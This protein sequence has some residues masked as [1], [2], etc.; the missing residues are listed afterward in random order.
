M[1]DQ[2]SPGLEAFAFLG[3]L[4]KCSQLLYNA[5]FRRNFSKVVT[6]YRNPPN[7]M[8]IVIFDWLIAEIYEKIKEGIKSPQSPLRLCSQR[9]VFKIEEYLYDGVWI[10]F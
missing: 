9:G 5:I 2:V 7:D 4:L 1:G 3:V 10:W 6:H 8:E